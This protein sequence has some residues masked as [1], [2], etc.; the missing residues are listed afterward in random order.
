M[1][2]NIFFLPVVTTSEGLYG[3][4]L[5]DIYLVNLLVVGHHFKDADYL[6]KAILLSFSSK[7]AK[8][9]GEIHS[10]KQG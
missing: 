3:V 9:L 7:S 2:K 10:Y 6:V 4:S 1:Q 5:N 8:L